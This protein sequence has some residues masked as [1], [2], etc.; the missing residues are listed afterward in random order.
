MGTV[1]HARL[2]GLLS[3][4]KGTGVFTWRV[5][6]GRVSVGQR[7]GCI[8]TSKGDS[9]RKIRIDGFEYFDSRLAWFYVTGA[10]PER[11]VDHR[12]RDSLNCAW[13]NLRQATRLKQ[14]ANQS[15]RVT[16]KSQVK[17]V[18]ASGSKYLAAIRIDGKL[19]HLGTFDTKAGAG[20]AYADKAIKLHGEFYVGDAV[21]CNTQL[22]AVW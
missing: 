12:D 22:E 14:L 3:F 21:N 5:S 18:R 4:D 11:E 13:G 2:L 17:G 7:A 1:T 15:V 19:T 6:V 8:K 20:K 16:S 10:W 9:R